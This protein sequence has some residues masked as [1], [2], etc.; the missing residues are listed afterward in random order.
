MTSNQSKEVI[1]LTQYDWHPYKKESDTEA[2][3][4]DGVDRW[5]DCPL[6]AREGAWDRPFP[7][8]PRRSQPE[9]RHS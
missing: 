1:S 6:G 5:G 2:Q 8:S 7:H 9:L 3:Q 4:E